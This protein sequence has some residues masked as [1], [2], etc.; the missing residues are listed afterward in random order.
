MRFVKSRVAASLVILGGLLWAV[1]LALIVAPSFPY[2]IYRIR[3]E[4]SYALEK[5]VVRPAAVVSEVVPEDRAQKEEVVLPELDP[6]L[7]KENG[8]II[9][10]IGVKTE[11]LEGENP[12][13]VIRKGVWRVNNFGSP[14][15]RSRPMI[16]A[17][18]RFGY[19]AWSNVYRRLNSF[20]NLPKLRVGDSIEVIWNQRKY[21]YEIYGESEGD[22]ITDYSAD[23]ILYTCK[24]FN[25]PVRVFRYA[26]LKP[27]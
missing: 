14:E 20:Y 1:S 4:T 8:L 11:I 23:L 24:L 16:L 10:K 17:A 12:E 18:H 7:P 15:D 3:P 5:V 25:S 22:V 21:E 26:R 27:A 9:P 6:S 13:E 19:L 2:V